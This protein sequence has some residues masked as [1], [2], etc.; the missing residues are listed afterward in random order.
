MSD[1]LELHNDDCLNVFKFIPDQSVD[2]V[3]TDCP[4]KIVQGGG[5]KS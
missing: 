4:Y 2:L 1:I 3:V 5:N